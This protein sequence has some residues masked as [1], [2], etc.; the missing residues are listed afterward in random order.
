MF[1]NRKTIGQKVAMALK[2]ML[3]ICILQLITAV[4]T[5]YLLVAIEKKNEFAKPQT[6]SRSIFVQPTVDGKIYL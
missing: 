1:L 6:L 4:K 2:I 3:H 5:K